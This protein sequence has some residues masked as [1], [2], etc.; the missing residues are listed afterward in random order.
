[1]GLPRS[2]LGWAI[3]RQIQNF[4][5][6]G[7]WYFIYQKIRRNRNTSVI[8]RPATAWTAV[9]G[10][11]SGARYSFFLHSGQIGF[12]GLLASYPMGN[13]G[14]FFGDKSAGL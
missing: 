4:F 7:G 8:E 11:S 10:L 12:G 13:R 2:D 6:G 9:V 14:I 1:M 3:W 5:L